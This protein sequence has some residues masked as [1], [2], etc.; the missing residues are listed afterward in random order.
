MRKFV[1]KFLIVFIRK[2]RLRKEFLLDYR[3]FVKYSSFQKKLDS[4]RMVY[5]MIILYHAI[6]K[7]F[8]LK[9]T[10]LG[11]GKQN[12]VE[13]LEILNEY[14]KSG[15]DI[16]NIHFLSSVAVLQ[17]Y[18]DYHKSR[19]YDVVYLEEGI[20][21]FRQSNLNS[22]FVTLTKKSIL[23]EI[24]KGFDKFAWSRHSIRNYSGKNVS[25]DDIE[26]AI[27]IAQS[28]PS[29]CNRQS[30]KVYIIQTKEM[31]QKIIKHHRG[32]R[33]FNEFADKFLIVTTSYEAFFDAEERYQYYID[34]GIY[35]MALVYALH[36]KGVAT[37]VLNWSVKNELDD[38]FKSDLSVPKNEVI[39][40][41][42]A[43]GEYPDTFYVSSSNR[44]STKDIINYR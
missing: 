8:T 32:S 30:N 34:G 14:Q 5:R 19:H 36:F 9:N 2:L 24:N 10:R 6:E 42:I 26:I 23:E 18:I 40:A 3:K 4:K 16:T 17:D 35:L 44:T 31:I 12:I 38:L 13:L 11:F 33:G 15:Y 27:N 43:L 28:A 1:P 7:A 37:C 20:R 25:I 41:L 21:T 29:A 39:I 22:G